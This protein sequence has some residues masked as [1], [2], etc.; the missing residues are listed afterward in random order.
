MKRDM[1]LI[2]AI[3]EYVEENGRMEGRPLD[4]PEFPGRW[5][6]DA[7][8]Y[9]LKLCKEVSFMTGV[10]TDQTSFLPQLLTWNGHEMLAQLRAD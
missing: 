6:G 5:E 9:H 1:N 2:K 10:G 3:L 4:K 7:V 8:E